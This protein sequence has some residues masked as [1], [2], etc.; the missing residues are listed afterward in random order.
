MKNE[1]TNIVVEFAL[2]KEH[3]A[4]GEKVR[5]TR[6]AETHLPRAGKRAG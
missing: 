5:E 2:P 1:E 3:F 6:G 4:R